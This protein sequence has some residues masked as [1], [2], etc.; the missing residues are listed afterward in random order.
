MVKVIT[1]AVNTIVAGE[2][3]G[4]EGEQMGLGEG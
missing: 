3:V 2:T 1:I 4:A